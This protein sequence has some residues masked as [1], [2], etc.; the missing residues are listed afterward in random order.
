METAE[1]AVHVH[2]LGQVLHLVKVSGG[3]EE[4]HLILR[5]LQLTVQGLF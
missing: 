5:K 3:G 4:N 1:L 2:C